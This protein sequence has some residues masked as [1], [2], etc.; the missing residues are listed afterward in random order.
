MNIL[1][2]TSAAPCQ[3]PFSTTEKRP[4]LGIGFLISVLRNAGH[5]VYFIDNYLKPSNF[6][7][8][9]FLIKNNIDYIGIYANTICFRDT[10]RMCYKIEYLRQKKKWNGKIIVGG[11]H[12]TVALDTIPNFVDYIVQ[13]EGEK[14]ILE[15]V[16]GRARNKIIQAERITDLDTL[17]M[18]AWDY[19]VKMPYHWQVDWFPQH[20]VFTMN[21]SRG[22]PFK[23]AFCSVGSIWGKR[24]TYFSAERIVDE[25]EFLIK[26]YGAA[27]I[28][29]R[30]DNFTLNRK[31]LIKFCELLIRKNIK[32]PWACETRV[33]SLDKEIVELMSRAG[34]CGFYFGVESGSQK[35]LNDLEKNITIDQII[36]AFELCHKY[37]I[38]TAASVIVGTPT[39]S[40]DDLKQTFQLIK[41]IKP[42]VTWYNVFV[43]IPN[44]KLH[45]YCLKNN[46]YEFIDDRGLGYL[47]GHNERVKRFYGNQIKAEVP[48][49]IDKKEGIISPKVSVI[50]SVFNGERYIKQAIKSILNQT[51]LDFEFIIIN[52]GSTDNTADIL[53]EFKDKRIKIINNKTNLGLTASLNKAISL[54]R[55]EFIAR[56]DAD[57]ISL[58]Y[59]FEYQVEFLE[60][61]PDIALVGSSYYV[62]DEKDEIKS[63]VEVLTDPDDLK[64][65]LEK[66]NWFGHGTVMLRKTALDIVGNYDESYKYAQD[67][68]LWLRIAN[69]FNIANIKEP[70]YIWRKTKENISS[71][72]EQEQSFYAQRAK[73]NN[74]RSEQ[75]RRNFN[76]TPLISVIVPTFN[77]PL[78]LQDAIN[79]ILKQTIDD[80]EIIVINDGGCELE[81]IIDSLNIN[82]KI[83]YVKHNTNKGLAAARNTGLKLAKGKYIAYLDDDDIFYSNH[84]ETLIPVLEKEKFKIVYS[85]AYRA[86]QV[87]EEN[88]Y[89]TIRKDI[90]YSN[91]FDPNQL[92]VQNIAPINCF[93][94]E[95]E[96]LNKTGFFD[97]TLTTHE[98]WDFWIRFSRH[99]EFKHLPKVTSEFRFRLDKSSMTGQIRHDF[100]RTANIIYKRYKKLTENNPKIV[101][102]QKRFLQ[103]LKN[104]I[105]ESNDDKVLKPKIDRTSQYMKRMASSTSKREVW[106]KESSN[107]KIL[108]KFSLFVILKE[109][110]LE[111]LADTLD[112]LVQQIYGNWK[113]KVIS[114]LSCV[115]PI[116]DEYDELTWIQTQDNFW[117]VINK[118]AFSDNT[119][120]LLFLRAGDRLHPH[121]LASL[122]NIIN[123]NFNVKFIYSDHDLIC[124]EEYRE[125]HFKPDINLDLLRSTDYIKRAFF[126]KK[127]LFQK[128]EGF[129]SKLRLT[130]T[131]DLILRTYDELSEKEIFHIEDVLISLSEKEKLTSEELELKKVASKLA[132]QNHLNR[133]GLKT[134]VI[135]GNLPD[136]FRCIYDY[137]D[138]PLISILIPTKDQVNLLRTCIKSLLQKTRYKNFEILIIDN[139][140]EDVNTI[141]FLKKIE[142]EY[143][144][145][146]KIINY[147]EPFNYSEAN[148]I[149]ARH[150]KGEYLLFL[151]ND[152]EI[153]QE[154]WLNILLSYC[155]RSEIG[156]VGARLLF[157]DGSLQHAGV[158]CGL[159]G[160]AG[161]P[162]V[163]ASLDDPGYM[164]RLQVDQNFS[165]VTAAC[166]LV[167]R[168][169]FEKVGGFDQEKYQLNFSDVDF[170]L[171]L[172]KAG[173]KTVWTPH[174]SLVHHTNATQRSLAEDPIKAEKAK[175]QFEK[176]KQALIDSWFP[177]LCHD[178]A[179]NY[180]LSLD[181][182][183]FEL[184]IEENPGWSPAIYNIP[185]IW[186]F[187]RA[188][189]GAGEYRIR[190][191]LAV[192][193][194]QGLALT[195]AARN[196]LV[197]NALLRH[198][199]DT[200]LFQTPTAD[201]AL[202]YMRTIKKYH[203]G[204]MIFEIDDLLHH[205]PFKNPAFNNLKGT[206][207]KKR[208]KEA[209]SYCD[210]MIVSTKP[211]A[212]AYAGFCKDIRI[213]PNYISKSVWGNIK[214]SHRDGKKPRV[215][216]A[217]GAFHYGDLMVI[218]DVVKDLADEVDWIFM[219]MCPDE[220]RPFVTE[221]HEGVEIDEYPEKL[222]SLDLDLAIAPLEINAFNRAKSNLRILEYGILGWPVVATDI[223]PYQGA[224]VTL[225][226]NRYKAWINA[227]RTKISDRD[228]LI[229][230]GQQLRKWILENWILEDHLDEI[231]D[232]YI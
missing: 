183:N 27:G 84:F 167:K 160:D 163:G 197:P 16:E 224:P 68:D 171:S 147:N 135:D 192:L 75:V 174:V 175:R 67:Y 179:Y 95:K 205:V 33:N 104:S 215:G 80:F 62:C 74:K 153:I 90:P 38:N 23:C 130:E 24:Y 148:N 198:R 154:N 39:E 12:T 46:L 223:Y 225:V 54:A 58:P 92:L 70:L 219:G 105:K 66:Q 172:Q 72:K 211:L 26:K 108:P 230:E 106:E 164:N 103:S 186:A 45:Q 40:E 61:N 191:P 140:S 177:V 220:I 131:Y 216:W 17:P 196:M 143:P 79:S 122:T 217:G 206:N 226:K 64:Q 209:V 47:K 194:E 29:F 3:A 208:I 228:A 100:L 14:A 203:K 10:L 9:N 139:D 73:D 207:L 11:P 124:D 227:I 182:Q 88:Q 4:P 166:M 50:M 232:A 18:P 114:H 201:Q 180:N 63:I 117:D 52:D 76:T 204:L 110:E 144:S 82:R 102:A 136:T 35:V 49:R 189:D 34:A 83:T 6:I 118:H 221:Y 146:I 133:N 53:K 32:I 120:W 125:P 69:K 31:R 112:S 97:E 7:E 199:V 28:Y 119:D 20:P 101:N 141:N 169:A 173:Y 187:P 71:K 195:H 121:S 107:W 115:S 162:F 21:T 137:K 176:D 65:G 13:G 60:N 152:T 132:I 51:Y 78:M 134:Q 89:K 159:Y 96:C 128:I 30:E 41:K 213:V 214:S 44:S 210:R 86:I 48:V 229:A 149:G 156:A 150:A 1:L 87:K 57:D 5:N 161:H 145:I 19:F 158:I 185:R 218:K 202:D 109:S 94:H 25:I 184:D 37:K 190:R 188:Q 151:N 93:I 231:L 15:I 178:P 2:T 193:Q 81:K 98:D 212:E 123:R 91:D 8:N 42:T 111:A 126:I 113:L 99:F 181:S 168:E 127:E 142:E 55:G 200:I 129:N 138:E 157:P 36:K 165:A 116:F 43:G 170:C 22:C 222:A 77:R 59:R 56:M 155:Q 85:D